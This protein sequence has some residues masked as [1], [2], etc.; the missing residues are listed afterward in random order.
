MTDV[1]CFGK[2]SGISVVA[3]VSVGGFTIFPLLY[4]W[5]II[6]EWALGDDQIIGASKATPPPPPQPPVHKRFCICDRPW[7]NWT[8]F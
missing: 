8:E 6:M 7:G 2:N 5:N 4:Y 3:W 1:A